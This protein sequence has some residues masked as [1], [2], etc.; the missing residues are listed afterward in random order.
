MCICAHRT[1]S[2]LAIMR[3]SARTQNQT[4][5]ETHMREQ[6]NKKKLTKAIYA[7]ISTIKKNNIYTTCF[8][9][10]GYIS[11]EL[12]YVKNNLLCTINVSAL[13]AFQVLIWIKMPC[14]RTN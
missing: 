10:S 13:A 2:R 3:K 9:F 4:A 6:R 14:A 11:R 12:Y 1:K 7:T 8:A 5:Q